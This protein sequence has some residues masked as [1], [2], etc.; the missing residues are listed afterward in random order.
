MAQV[1]FL[2]EIWDIESSLV[3]QWQRFWVPNVGDQ[4]LS[5]DRTRPN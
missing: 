2:Q 3:V 4:V 5:L 1:Q